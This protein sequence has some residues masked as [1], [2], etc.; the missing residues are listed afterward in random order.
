MLTK[1]TVNDKPQISAQ[2][3]QKDKLMAE[4][5]KHIVSNIQ[6]DVSCPMKSAAKQTSEFKPYTTS[7]MSML[8]AHWQ[9][10]YMCSLPDITPAPRTRQESPAKSDDSIKLKRIKKLVF[11]SSC[12]CGGRCNSAHRAEEWHNGSEPPLCSQRCPASSE[13]LIH[14]AH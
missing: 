11:R 13:E 4:I 10:W 6:H 7:S 12:Q 1:R 9:G 5:L 8:P 2:N 14:P 3:K